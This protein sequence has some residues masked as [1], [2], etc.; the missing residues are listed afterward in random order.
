MKVGVVGSRTF[1][2]YDLMCKTLDAYPIK[3]IISGGAYGADKLAEYYARRHHLNLTVHHP[4]YDRYGKGATHIRNKLIV[5]ESDIIVAFWNGVS[6]GT[7]STISFA[8][9]AGKKVVIVNTEEI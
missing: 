9:Q 1:G 7:F 3:E 5:D 6:R 8:R 2:D 4:L